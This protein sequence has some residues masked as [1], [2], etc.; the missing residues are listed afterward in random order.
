MDRDLIN[1]IRISDEYERGVE[2]FI[3]FVQRNSNNSGHDG[4]KFRYPCVNYLDGRRLDVNKIMVFMILYN[5][6]MAW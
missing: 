1:S 3:Q 2:E 4:V 5:L 6:D